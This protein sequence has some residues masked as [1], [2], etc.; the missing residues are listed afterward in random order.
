LRE[1]LKTTQVTQ[2]RERVV[3]TA[4]LPAGFLKKLADSGE[5]SLSPVP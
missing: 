5:A 4:T 1:L 2:R 3:I